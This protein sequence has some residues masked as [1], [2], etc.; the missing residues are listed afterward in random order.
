MRLGAPTAE[1]LGSCESVSIDE[2]GSTKVA[3]FNNSDSQVSTLLIRGSTANVLDDV[4]R[5]VDDCVN[6]FKGM[7]K[8][9]RFLAGA[10]A[11]EIRLASALVII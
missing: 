8:D 6:A 4:E 3:F 10:G 2:V 1:E 9:N 11:T 7:L 5:C